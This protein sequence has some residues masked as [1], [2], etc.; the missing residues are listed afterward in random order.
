MRGGSMNSCR[1]WALIAL[2]MCVPPCLGADP[3]YELEQALAR[4]LIAT[5][6]LEDQAV[7]KA[8]AR[9][10]AHCRQIKCD[11]DLRQCLM[12][13]DREYFVTFTVSNVSH[14]LTVTEMKEA[15]AYFRSE[16]GLK[17]LDVLRAE[18][19]LGGH[20][21]IFNQTPAIRARMLTFLDTRAGY[22]LITRA[23]LRDGVNKMASMQFYEA[24]DRCMPAR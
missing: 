10:L 12:K 18:Q 9:I 5:M 2:G 6:N 20:D 1:L 4:E 7:Q 3:R 13:I 14:E 21:T 15:I 23:V 11:A 16:P 19:G 24:F 22:L 8:E 17:H